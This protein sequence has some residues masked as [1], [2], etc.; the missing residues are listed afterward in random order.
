MQFH[1]R[2]DHT[3]NIL[4]SQHIGSLLIKLAGPV[5]MG[6]FVQSF[7]NII[8]TIFMG[9]FVNSLAIAAL[10][11]VFPIQMIV[12]GTSQMVGMGGSSLISRFIG[13]GKMAD[14]ER[15]AGNGVAASLIMGLALTII[16]LPFSEFWLKLIG[17]D[18]AVMVYAKPYLMIIMSCASLNIF[19]MALLAYVRAEG[20]TRVG[21]IA[22]LIGAGLSIIL[23]AIFVIPLK[24]GVVGA[25]LATVIAQ[26]A[27]M[28]YLV[29]YY[30]S[31]SS[32]L[33][34]RLSN[35]RLD[36]VILK[37]MF[38]V[39]VSSFV[40][41]AASSLSTILLI[42]LILN[43]GGDMELA[44]YGIV[45]RVLM[46]AGMPGMVIGQALQPILGYNYGAKRYSLGL[47]SIKLSLIG[48]TVIMSLAFIVVYLIPGPIT[49]IFTDDAALVDASVHASKLIFL[50]LPLM[51]AVNVGQVIFQALGKAMRS[52][53]TAI[54]RPVLFLIPL[55]YTLSHFW[56]LDG[57]FLSFPASD[58]LTLVLIF[59]LTMPVIREFRK[60]AARQKEQRQLEAVSGEILT[61]P[62]KPRL[63]E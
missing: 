49:R 15:T 10:S 60:M 43:Y 4:D 12:W 5:F 61:V 55:V 56:K 46:F 53:I 18:A 51:G 24:M 22:M 35:L 41:I 16:V 31:G 36:A 3:H 42:N 32:Y 38:A 63:A 7:Y 33:K 58:V 20:N 57:V 40:Q 50:S 17:T 39:G 47:K 29:S 26:I 45:Q 37:P 6:M 25:G 34:L 9:Q 19:A 52:F 1:K 23:D 21:M 54:V 27:S 59:F 48:S 30:L 28:I 44:A 14:A 13:A 8:N 62:G 2:V 11:I